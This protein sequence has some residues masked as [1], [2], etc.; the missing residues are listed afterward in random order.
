MV[1]PKTLPFVVRDSPIH[2]KGMF[3]AQVI[4]KGTRIIAYAGERIDK[5]EAKRRA[6]AGKDM[7]VFYL[8]RYHDLDGAHG[9]NESQFVNHSCDNNARVSYQNGKIYYV[10]VRDIQK[11][12]EIVAD[13]EMISDKPEPCHCGAKNC[14]GFMNEESFIAKMRKREQKK[15]HEQLFC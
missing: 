8:D 7:Y 9:G 15:A 14:R 5:R 2:G 13:Y 4:R 3:A 10:A 1:S 6:D 12:E 11:G